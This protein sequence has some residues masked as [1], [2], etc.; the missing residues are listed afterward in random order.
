MVKNAFSG[1]FRENSSI[2]R[3]IK[4]KIPDPFDSYQ[5]ISKK[6]AN[7][8]VPLVY[9]INVGRYSKFDKNISGKKGL[10]QLLETLKKDGDIGIHPSYYSNEQPK[11][12]GQEIRKMRS[13][14]NGPVAASRQHYLRLD[15]PGTYRQLIA[16]GIKED[17]S[18]GYATYP[19]FRAGTCSEFNWFDLG[20]NQCTD[21]RIKPVTWMEGTFAE[22]LSLSP[23]EAWKMMKKLLHTV[24]EYNGHF[25]PI[26]HNHTIAE[27]GLYKGWRAVFEQMLNE[28]E[29]I[30]YEKKENSCFSHQ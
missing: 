16:N 21:L 14:L 11:L 28:I 6:L 12:F 26:W 19:G 8:N 18:M 23:G 27:T 15:L 10:N 30:P 1:R 22:D 20:R 29:C 9:F 2:V 4:G 7:A 25:I 24:Y 17:Y 3:T 5:Y 13:I